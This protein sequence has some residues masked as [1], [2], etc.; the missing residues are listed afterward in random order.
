MVSK[1]QLMKTWIIDAAA[2]VNN[3]ELILAEKRLDMEL[4]PDDDTGGGFGFL[5]PQGS[6]T[7]SLMRWHC[8]LLSGCFRVIAS[9]WASKQRS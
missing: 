7:A 9:S 3:T 1:N 5:H 8:S 4:A 6:L 2:M